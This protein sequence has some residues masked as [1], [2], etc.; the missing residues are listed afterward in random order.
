VRK[1]DA[2]RYSS[3]VCT[4]CTSRRRCDAVALQ[5]G[6]PIP[7]RAGGIDE[8]AWKAETSWKQWHVLLVI[9]AIALLVSVIIVTAPW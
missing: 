3:K 7:A 2:A 1:A 9:L 4:T 6:N 5:S 8:Y